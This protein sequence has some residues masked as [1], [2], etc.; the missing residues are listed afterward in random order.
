MTEHCFADFQRA[1]NMTDEDGKNYIGA[2]IVKAAVAA[3]ERTHNAAVTFPV[4][5]LGRPDLAEEYGGVPIE[6]LLDNVTYRER[7]Q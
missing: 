7:V 5:I 3:W 4:R 6:I 1:G 2:A